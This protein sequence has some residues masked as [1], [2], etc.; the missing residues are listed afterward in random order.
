LTLK[1]VVVR[2]GEVVPRKKQFVLTREQL[3]QIELERD[4]QQRVI[5]VARLKGWLVYSIPDSRRAT[6][7]GFPDLTLIRKK[8]KRLIFAELKREKGRVSPAQQDVLDALGVISDVSV[9]VWRPSQWQ[10][11]LDILT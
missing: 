6:L 5:E 8:D 1:N 9:Y 7:A 4:F 11:I 3:A 2:T 10:S